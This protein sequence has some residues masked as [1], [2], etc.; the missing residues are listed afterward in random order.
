MNNLDSVAWH[1]FSFLRKRTL[2]R[3]Y[4][5]ESHLAINHIMLYPKLAI[6]EHFFLM[7]NPVF[8]PSG[9]VFLI[10]ILHTKYLCYILFNTGNN[11]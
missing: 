9:F 1:I 10:E 6:D 2:I 11:I 8:D 7:S 3:L 5:H 4:S